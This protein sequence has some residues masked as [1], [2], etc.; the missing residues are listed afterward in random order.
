MLLHIPL[1]LLL[2]ILGGVGRPH[3]RNISGSFCRRCE[4]CDSR[5]AILLLIVTTTSR[6]LNMSVLLVHC[7]LAVTVG[8]FLKTK[9]KIVVFWAKLANDPAQ[10]C[11]ALRVSFFY[12]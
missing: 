4:C 12:F 1:H 5:N 8:F 6:R 10:Q 7:Q 9:N 3:P 2:H 11:E